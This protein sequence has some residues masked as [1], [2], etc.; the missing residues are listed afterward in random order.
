MLGITIDLTNSR[1]L[2]YGVDPRADDALPARGPDPEPPAPL[3]IARRRRRCGCRADALRP[4]G[5]LM[6]L[7]RARRRHASASAAS[8]RSTR[9]ISRSKPGSI[10]AMIGPNGAGKS[11]VF[12][13]ITGIYAPSAG[14]HR[15]ST[16]RRSPA[17]GPSAIAAGGIAR[18]FQ[19]IRLFAFMSALDNVMTGEHA[20]MRA[21]VLD[22]LLHTPRAARRGTAR[23]RT[24]AA[25]CCASSASSR[26]PSQYAQQSRLRPAAPARDRARAR[27]ANRSCCC[28]TSPRPA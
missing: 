15:A 12:N 28:S 6:A 22:S 10:V 21:N 17:S 26:S 4:G 14:P 5:A 7:L 3:R 11:T 18:T 2:I 13:L 24:R 27:R 9:S 1:F 16:A 8:S 20:R 23:A 25:S 19:N